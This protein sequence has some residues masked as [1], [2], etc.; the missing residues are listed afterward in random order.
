MG[1]LDAVVTSVNADAPLLTVSLQLVIY[2]L[3][4]FCNTFYNDPFPRNKGHDL[5]IPFMTQYS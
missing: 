1:I 3:L 4:L 2:D 5:D